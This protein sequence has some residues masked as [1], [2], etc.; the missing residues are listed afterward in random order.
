MYGLRHYSN[1]VLVPF[2]YDDPLGNSP[3]SGPFSL[4]A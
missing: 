2:E 1:N 3:A 4:Y